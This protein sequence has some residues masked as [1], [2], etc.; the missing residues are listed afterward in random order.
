[1][2]LVSPAFLWQ[3]R[4]GFLTTDG[5]SSEACALFARAGQPVELALVSR[6]P[7]AAEFFGGIGGQAAPCED[8]EKPKRRGR[9]AK[10]E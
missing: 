7:N 2:R 3:T 8:E 6:F 9:P 5:N 1:M 10:G 4:S